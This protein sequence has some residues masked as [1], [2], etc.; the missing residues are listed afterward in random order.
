MEKKHLCIVFL[1]ISVCPAKYYVT[2]T[3]LHGD[4]FA[5]PY[6]PGKRKN[7]IYFSVCA[8]VAVSSVKVSSVTME[9]RQWV[10]FK[11]SWSRKIF[12]TVINYDKY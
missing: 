2:V 9:M 3:V 7:N 1:I 12:G 8:D 6:L 5:Q 10:P 4:A 11:L